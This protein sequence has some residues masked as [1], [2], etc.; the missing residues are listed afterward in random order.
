MA[1]HC[2]PA[3]HTGIRQVGPPT[4]RLGCRGAPVDDECEDE[5]RQQHETARASRQ[6]EVYRVHQCVRLKAS[7]HEAWSACDSHFTMCIYAEQVAHTWQ[8]QLGSLHH[9]QEE[10]GPQHAAG[11]L[12]CGKVLVLLEAAGAR[13]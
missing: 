6:P 2:R 9:L 7:T 11:E 12:R 4:A 1:F 8:K 3:L 13:A 5:E 10:K